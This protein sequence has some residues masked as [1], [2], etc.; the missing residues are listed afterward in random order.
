MK[1]RSIWI[2]IGLM[3]LALTG[4]ITLQANW[5]VSTIKLNEERFDKGVASAIMHLSE[6]LEKKERMAALE[7]MNGFESNFIEQ[8]LRQVFKGGPMEFPTGDLN[9]SGLPNDRLAAFL[10]KQNSCD[11]E[12]CRLDRKVQYYQIV[13]KRFQRLNM[14]LSERIGDP[15]I[16]HAILREELDNAGI[17]TTYHYGVYSN[18][19]NNFIINN[20]HYVVHDIN[21]QVSR[22]GGY[23]E[24]LNSQYRVSLFPEG[25][26]VPGFLMIYFPAKNTAVWASVIRNLVASILFM[27]IILFCFAYTI[28]I[29][30]RQKK[31]SEMKNDFI[32]NMTHEF[33]TPIATISLAADAISSPTI[34]GN[35]DKVKRFADIIRQENRRMNSHVEQVLQMA[36]LD[37]PKF[38]ISTGEVNIH[39]VITTAIQNFELQVE[40]RDGT[41]QTAL[42]ADNFTIF[43][44]STHLSAAIHNLLDNAN[45]YSPEQPTI[46]V[47]TRNKSLALII[48]VEDRGIGI[49]KDSLKH[50]F[51]KFYR[52]H[53][54]NRHDV[55]GFGLGLGYV[56]AIMDAHNGEI[57]VASEPGKGS[58]FSLIF[59]LKRRNL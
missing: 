38:E 34:S 6:R 16:L 35:A 48:E 49:Q 56:K 22:G 3:T 12:S 40:Q 36:L 5:I 52:V 27:A 20:G 55:K 8:E 37:K 59:P 43:G 2:I 53:T 46:M 13:Q 17:S 21:E 32:N 29:I 25:Q 10:I 57:K 26:E 18:E 7:S 24:L 19:T 50:I 42:N 54:G 28:M 9:E 1:R 11:C 45:K 39:E 58:T 30:F 44:D 23:D 33:K 47:R 14:D 4:I 51:D 31:V 41:I 15:R